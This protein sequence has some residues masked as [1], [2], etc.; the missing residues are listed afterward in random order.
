MLFDLNGYSDSEDGS[1]AARRPPSHSPSSLE[2]PVAPE[3][4]RRRSEFDKLTLK[5]LVDGPS[6]SGAEPYSCDRMAK[7]QSPPIHGQ[8]KKRRPSHSAAKVAV[9]QKKPIKQ[10]AMRKETLPC[11]WKPGDRV[12]AK[13]RAQTVGAHNALWFTGR[14]ERVCSGGKRFDIAFDDGDREE[15]VPQKFLRV[16]SASGSALKVDVDSVDVV[17]THAPVLEGSVP[18]PSPVMQP[19]PEM[20]SK[21]SVVMQ[22]SPQTLPHSESE[23][24]DLSQK[25]TDLL[26]KDLGCYGIA[27]EKLATI[28]DAVKCNRVRFRSVR[29]NLKQN[30]GVLLAFARGEVPVASIADGTAFARPAAAQ[31]VPCTVRP[32]CEEPVRELSYQYFNGQYLPRKEWGE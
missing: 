9:I 4:R 16:P 6:A 2:V 27:P 22:Q 14:I 12:E 5:H 28:V 10:H 19:R 30:N 1:P 23:E 29:F 26:V 15:R 3:T 25:M 32:L 8:P 18:S 13:Y 17:N 11:A 21:L 20:P 31:D 7:K 24:G